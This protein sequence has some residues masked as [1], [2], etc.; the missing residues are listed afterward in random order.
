M[1]S[2]GIPLGR[3]V[4]GRW[5]A[6]AVVLAFVLLSG[7]VLGSPLGGGTDTGVSSGLGRQVESVRAAALKAGLPGSRVNPA[8][9]VYSRDGAA[10]TSADQV[11]IARDRAQLAPL[12]VGGALPPP[13]PAQDGR[14]V[15]VPV[16]LPSSLSDAQV[17]DA[18][19][20]IRGVTSAGLPDGARAQ[21]TGGPAIST[22][23]ASAFD[24][25]DTK[26]L[27]TTAG[28]VAL[29]LL[30]TYR[31]PVLWII[32]LAVVGTAD[33]VGAKLTSALAGAL[34]QPLDGSSTGIASVLVFGA[35]TNYALLVIARYREELRRTEDHREAMRTALASS[36]PA[37]A[38]SAVT[39]TLALLTLLFASLGGSR[40]IGWTSALGVV[41]VV[42]C[43]LLVLPAALVLC[44]RR[45]FWP[46]IPR[47]G[48]AD[49]SHRGPWARIARA[50][51]A[52]PAA[53]AAA[54]VAVLVVLALGISGARLGLSATEQFRVTSESAAGLETLARHFPAGAGSPAE[55]LTRRDAAPAVVDTVTTVPGVVT[56]R[57]SDQGGDV[58]QVDA[59]LSDLPGTA[60]SYDTLRAVRAAVAGV[61]GA[62]A[63]VGGSVA[64]TLDTREA[65]IRDLEVIVPMILA[66][67]FVVLILLLRSLVAPLLLIATVILSFFASLGASHWAFVHVFGF[68]ALDTLVPLLA[69]LF[70]VALGVDY[71]IFLTTRAREEA[72]RQGTRAGIVTAVAVTGGV[73][74]SAG[75]LLAA[76]FTVLGVL[77][78]IT[79]TQ[80]GIIVGFGVLLDTLLVRTVLVPALVTLL[81]RR[82][83]WPGALSR[84]D[85]DGSR[86]GDGDH[87]GGATP[88]P[89]DQDDRAGASRIAPV[90]IPEDEGTASAAGDRH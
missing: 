83:W 1:R 27:L 56:A 87:D 73:I 85:G 40:S 75:I 13:V 39:V 34:D 28:I 51:V 44:G 21:V 11:A 54:S 50:V 22:D 45:L 76:V 9:V 59:V 35:G 52:R 58:A 16:P 6:R 46:F 41:V 7:A 71:N 33:Q 66:V 17:T 19:T 65:A 69:F 14:A 24:G 2:P 25:A 55:I 72:Q 89:P 37:V 82:V 61:P 30:L 32:P 49:L 80:I 57:I 60:A 68:P 29:L 48:D 38:G 10:L 31:S 67:V 23:I 12:A 88:A 62:D 81:G 78:L 15:L 86:R 64:T 70:L 79:L 5:G 4:T 26:L 90:L 43:A 42:V 63:V 74:T 84:A 77:P 36:G 53:V 20:A 8:I 3:L 47:A 18:V